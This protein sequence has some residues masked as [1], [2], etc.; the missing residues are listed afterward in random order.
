MP[1]TDESPD[2]HRE[3][4]EK[5]SAEMEILS[6]ISKD[7]GKRFVITYHDYK[8]VYDS[9]DYRYDLYIKMDYLTSLAQLYEETEF[10]VS[11][12][13]KMGIDVCEAL[14]WCHENGRVHN[15][16]NL[17]NIFI[18]KDGDYVLGDF[19]V[20][21]RIRNESEYC[22]APE[23][24]NGKKPDSISDVYSLGMVMFTLVNNG[25]PPFSA[26]ESDS[27]RRL[28]NGEKPILPSAI[29]KRLRD[30]I[31]SALGIGTKRCESA[32]HMKKML[33]A[34]SKDMPEKWLMQGVR[35]LSKC[36]F[37]ENEEK[38]EPQIPEPEIKPS[39][40]KEEKEPEPIAPEEEEMRKKNRKDFLILG[41]VVAVL[42]AI[43]AAGAFLLSNADNSKIKSLINS[44]SYS[45]A[46]KEMEELYD[47]G[48][49]ID[50]L[51]RYYVDACCN[52]GEY[53]RVVQAVNLFS[54]EAFN[55]VEYFRNMLDQMLS[56]GK[57]RQADK[58]VKILSEYEN[59]R[60]MLAEAGCLV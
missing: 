6:Q 59:M 32:E 3:L 30:V 10:K 38:P 31:S 36:N 33:V 39:K 17:N 9:D 12:M 45:V 23:L 13:L 25:L 60:P 56:S 51:V 2:I 48:K 34:L 11:D 43:V 42:I 27:A 1:F 28:R 44:G 54:D 29:S 14:A 52:D 26:D 46:Y 18:N 5:I 22:M 55:D 24:L 57:T 19:A 49:N 53:N 41:I 47:N 7:S 4:S 58:L 20:S 21:E 15:N 16:L 8:L 35:E 50:S 40:K 37:E